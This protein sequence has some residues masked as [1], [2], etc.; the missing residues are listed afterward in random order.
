MA[1]PGRDHTSW[2][3]RLFALLLCALACFYYYYFFAG[4][5]HV[6]LDIVVDQK[7]EFKLYWAGA[8]EPF[9][10]KRRAI[11]DIGPEQSSYSFFLTDLG[12]VER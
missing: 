6:A 12:K 2:S 4:R 8:N 5:S 1:E 11:V 10:E 3:S 7:T 9:S